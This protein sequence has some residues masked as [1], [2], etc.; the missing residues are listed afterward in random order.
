VTVTYIPIGC[1]K[2]LGTG[3]AGR[4][5]F[6]E[7]LSATEAL[8]QAI[9]HNPNIKDITA[10]LAETPFQKLSHAGYAMV[11]EGAVPFDEV[12]KAVGR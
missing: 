10:A 12:E 9:S 3:Y 8:R 1:Q 4:R 11:A 6:F 7:L 2:C 5:A